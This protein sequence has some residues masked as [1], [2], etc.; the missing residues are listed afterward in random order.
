MSRILIT[1]AAGFI[2]SRL[3]KQAKHAGHDVIATARRVSEKLELEMEMPVI[4]LDVLKPISLE[5]VGEIDAIVHCATANDIL[6][7]DFEAGV[8]LSVMGTRNILEFAKAHGIKKVIF[9]S[10][11][12]V[13]GTEL[14]GEISEDTTVSCQSAYA[15][16]HYFGEELCRMYANTYGLDVVL[17]RPANIYG[18]PDV[19]TVQRSTLVPM[20]FVQ[21]AKNTG[22]VTLRSSGLQRRNFI[23]THEVAGAC[24]HLLGDFPQGCNVVNLASDWLSNIL[25]IA[26][27]TTQVYFEL[28]K[29]PMELRVLSNEPRSGNHFTVQSRVAKLRPSKEASRQAMRNVITELFLQH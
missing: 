25:E 19:S 8:Q 21:D 14:S 28:Y 27:M 16:N 6:S 22:S 29:K 3:A 1:G 7:R 10:T 15:L 2:G 4:S 18:I 26:E 5:S 24:L 11:L 17:L 23:S 20:C 13:Y 9:L 12:Q